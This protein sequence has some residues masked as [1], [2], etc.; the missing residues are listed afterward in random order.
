MGGKVGRN[1]P[2]PCGSGKKY[3][4]CCGPKES[5][6]P[7]ILP[8]VLTGTS[9]D[10]YF[11]IIPAIATYGEKVLRFEKDGKE[12]KKAVSRFEKRFR[13]GEKG[14]I[15]DSFFMSWMQFDLRFG[16]SRETIAERFLNDPLTSGLME[17]G[18]S[19]VRE[20]AL[21]YFSFCEIIEPGP[22]A[23]SV[24][25]LVTGKRF[26]VTDIP[27]IYEIDPEPGEVFFSRLV[28]P[29]DAAIF[30][31]TPYVFG[32][33]ARTQLERVLRLQEED[34]RLSPAA[35]RFPPRAGIRRVA[36]RA[37]PFLG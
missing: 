7:L 3:K 24:K 28:G 21:S 32:P 30:F 1:D 27:E 12:L 36:E 9:Y 13:P 5:H 25:E 15:T 11:H 4:K 19:V 2:C 23:V 34:F 33:E 16:E 8:P 37:C 14:G 22:G 18:R 35:F 29:P 31:T 6:E 10:D 26:A 20:L 17:H